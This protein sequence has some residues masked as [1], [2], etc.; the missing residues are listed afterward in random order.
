MDCGQGK[1]NNNGGNNYRETGQASDVGSGDMATGQDGG[2]DG[3][4]S[5]REDDALGNTI[6][7]AGV[8][9]PIA[10]TPHPINKSV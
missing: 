7:I 3:R 10:G 8:N 6:A 5:D 9:Y 4:A 1:C 2:Q